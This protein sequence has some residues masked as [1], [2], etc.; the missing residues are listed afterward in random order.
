MFPYYDG[1]H[2]SKTE[3]DSIDVINKLVAIGT[4]PGKEQMSVQ[5]FKLPV[6]P[7]WN[8][9]KLCILKERFRLPRDNLSKVAVEYLKFPIVC[10]FANHYR[11]RFVKPY[12]YGYKEWVV[13]S[14]LDE[15]TG[16][17]INEDQT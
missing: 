17:E 7:F 12:Y 9:E 14:E 13:K 2:A 8:D 15:D 1:K 11:C 4:G 6:C 3:P 16:E 10:R 5:V